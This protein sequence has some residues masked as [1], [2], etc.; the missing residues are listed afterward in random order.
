MINVIIYPYPN[1][2]TLQKT[3]S[4]FT[5][6]RIETFLTKDLLLKMSF[7]LIVSFL[8]INFEKY[9]IKFFMM[10]FMHG[11]MQNHHTLMCGHGINAT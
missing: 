1:R 5:P 3:I 10:Q 6:F 2:A 9:S 4:P 11:F 7:I 8:K